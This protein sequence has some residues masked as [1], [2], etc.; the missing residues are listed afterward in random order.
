M[1]LTAALEVTGGAVGLFLGRAGRVTPMCNG[2][3][4]A[5]G[6]GLRLIIII[7][8]KGSLSCSLIFFSWKVFSFWCVVE[9]FYKLPVFE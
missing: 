6:E 8:Y 1:D 3:T 9:G 7:M 5:F 4:G 2:F